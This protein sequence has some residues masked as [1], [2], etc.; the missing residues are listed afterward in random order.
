[1]DL[2]VIVVFSILPLPR[3][4]YYEFLGKLFVGSPVLH[5]EMRT[6][7]LIRLVAFRAMRTN[8]SV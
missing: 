4:F 6:L 1:M 7:T 8:L 5:G 2:P 3:E